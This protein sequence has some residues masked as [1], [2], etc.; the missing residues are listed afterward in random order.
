MLSANK[1][2]VNINM[3]LREIDKK[4]CILIT[5]ATATGFTSEETIKCSQELDLLITQYQQA[6]VVYNKSRL[7]RT[8]MDVFSLTLI[9][10]IRSFYKLR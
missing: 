4:R 9:S 10:P 5:T 2:G 8:I 3:L 6:I 7:C 1:T